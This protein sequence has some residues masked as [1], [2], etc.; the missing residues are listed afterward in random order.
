MSGRWTARADPCEFYETKRLQPGY[1][2]NY[3]KSGDANEIECRIQT[4]PTAAATARLN[5]AIRSGIR[6]GA[7]QR[8]VGSFSGNKFAD[9]FR[10]PLR[11]CAG[12]DHQ[13]PASRAGT[14]RNRHDGGVLRR[15]NEIN[16]L[17]SLCNCF[18]PDGLR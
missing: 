6:A 9:E 11:R 7:R 16:K 8:N 10:R 4:G 12:D 2:G 3:E 13:P 15:R 1:L 17:Q 18:A 5:R 14:S